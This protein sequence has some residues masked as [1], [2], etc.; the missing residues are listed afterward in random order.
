M[1]WDKNSCKQAT[2]K[3]CLSYKYT[4]I[5]YYSTTTKS[6]EPNQEKWAE[7]LNKYFSK[8]DKRITSRHMKKININITNYQRKA[9]QNY[10]QIPT[11]TSQNGH[12]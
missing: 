8:E 2:D 9:N 1:E 7:D 12:H 4:I 5:S 3:G 11:H 6:K 10:N